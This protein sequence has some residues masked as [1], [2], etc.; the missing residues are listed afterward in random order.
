MAEVDVPTAL[1]MEVRVTG[2]LGLESEALSFLT[3]YL[4]GELWL[5]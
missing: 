1:F 2:F 4:L 3:Y 5:D